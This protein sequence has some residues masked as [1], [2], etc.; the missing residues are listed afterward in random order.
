[1]CFFEQVPPTDNLDV[2]GC[3]EADRVVTFVQE[4]KREVSSGMVQNSA[5]CTQSHRNTV[6]AACSTGSSLG[7]FRGGS[8]PGAVCRS[9]KLQ[10]KTKAPHEIITKCAF[11]QKN[12]EQSD[13]SK[14]S[15]SKSYYFIEFFFKTQTFS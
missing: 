15:R 6:G 10:P 3:A 12:R 14:C 7:A 1:M 5:K 11:P 2:Q 4:R 13:F 8:A 9:L